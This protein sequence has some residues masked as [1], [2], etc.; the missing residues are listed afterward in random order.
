[1]RPNSSSNRASQRHG[2][3]R[4]IS[5]ALL[6]PPVLQLRHLLPK[7]LA[8]ASVELRDFFFPLERFRGGGIYAGRGVPLSSREDIF[9][10]G[11]E[12]FVVGLFQYFDRF[13]HFALFA[14]GRVELEGF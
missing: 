10:F 2:K 4:S 6:E 11:V 1:M 14:A 3:G 8:S 7:D 9:H 5:D 13:L 12:G